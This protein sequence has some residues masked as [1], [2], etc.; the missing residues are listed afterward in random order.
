MDVARTA[1]ASCFHCHGR[2]ASGTALFIEVEGRHEP[3]CCAGCQAAAGFVLSQGLGRFYRF[4]ATPPRAD[5]RR[6]AHDW[7]VFDR[8]AAVARYTHRRPDGSREVGVK[9]EGMH[10]SACVWLIEN[11]V[12]RCEGV[13]N[14]SV[15]LVEGRAQVC[16]DPEAIPLSGVLRAFER[17]GYTP[18]P[19]SYSGSAPETTDER[20]A[21]L[22]RLAVA[23]FG[24]MQVMSFA[25]A[26][27]AGA[28]DGIAP[29][30]EQLLRYVSL[31]VAT[32][33][34]LYSAQPFFASAW[35]NLNAGTL[36]M[37]VPVA[38]S[39]GIAYGWSLWTTLRGSGPVYFDSAVMFTFLL[40]LGRYVQMSLQHRS[41]LRGDSLHGLL[42]ESVL[43]VTDA[44]AERVTP[45]EVC[46][47]DTIRILP[48]ERVPA[49]GTVTAGVAEIDESLI[50]G[51]SMPR[52]CRAG[53][54]VTAGTINVNG[55]AEVLV[56]RV[57]QDST[58]ATIGRLVER[59]QSVRPPVAELADRIAAWFVGGI[60]LVALVAGLYWAHRD[61]AQ[62]LPVV[63]AVL[64]VTCPCA[65]SLATPACLAAATA[66]LTRGG[67]LVT[68]TR[69]LERLSR[70]DTVIFDKTG[71]LTRGIPSIERT[72]MLQ[73]R[74]TSTQ[75]LQIAAALEA[76]SRHPVARAFASANSVPKATSVVYAPGRGIEGEVDGV[77]YRIGCAEYV[78]AGT[79]GQ[80]T[81][82]IDAADDQSLILLGDR[83]NALAAFLTADTLRNDSR[84]TVCDLQSLGLDVQIA[85]GDRAA[86][87]GKCA[88]QLKIVRARGG[89][90]ADAKLD[91]LRGLQKAGHRVAVV[92]D[93]INDA[94]VLAAADVSVAV[95]SGADLAQLNADMVLVAD[96]L[97]P[98]PAA[99][100]VTRRM[101]AIMRQNLAWAAAYNLAAVPMAVAGWLQPWVAAVGMSL[102]SLLVVL[103][104][105]RL[106]R[107]DAPGQPPAPSTQR[108]V[109][110]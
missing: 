42:P 56:T 106:L 109:A 12:T 88:A 35:R 40:L 39:I 57:G 58:L 98:L 101:R 87:V 1:L 3:V 8:T 61:A 34:V 79:N 91:L 55:V 25:A 15:N 49:D 30:L 85:S 92:G 99:I 4:R 80:H 2:I 65:L 97:S 5:T 41:A 28:F 104:A 67:L 46:V 43:R 50:T 6:A 36:G 90:S 73:E 51:E 95:G 72:V 102:S 11:S 75:C 69:G 81:A 18:R 74:A 96:A 9:L 105:L 84:R 78:L 59:A 89:M 62:V 16:Y 108:V 94:A 93:G 10:C 23:G 52:T 24:M 71:T 70:V 44:A 76:Y 77:R 110:G 66:R 14:V 45:D 21:A 53:D 64:V 19:S 31:L 103:N 38:L 37:D 63:L 48:G 107:T 68:R 47:G 13:L 26:L 22:K 32:P 82:S 83:Q 20:R 27:Y 86:V 17:I 29:S 54:P 33:V 7:T 60:L 100:R